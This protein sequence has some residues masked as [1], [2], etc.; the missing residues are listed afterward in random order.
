MYSS[1]VRDLW[2]RWFWIFG[3]GALGWVCLVVLFFASGFWFGFFGLGSL[4]C[5]I[6]L[7]LWRPEFQTLL[8]E[9][10]I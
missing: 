6:R 7:A 9:L 4:H 8:P 3:S 1:P 10:Y 2:D 5:N